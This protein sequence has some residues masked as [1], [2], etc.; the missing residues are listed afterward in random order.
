MSE[1]CYLLLL[2]TIY[3]QFLFTF[4]MLRRKYKIQRFCVD[5]SPIC[6]EPRE[7]K[8]EIYKV[9]ITGNGTGNRAITNSGMKSIICLFVILYY[10]LT[11]IIMTSGK[12][13]TVPD[14]SFLSQK[15]C[16]T[17]KF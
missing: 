9:Q 10:Y 5:L 4:S 11:F 6:F 12:L 13:D 1:F 16:S 7:L 15:R 8:F 14:M 3:L 17:V 2:F